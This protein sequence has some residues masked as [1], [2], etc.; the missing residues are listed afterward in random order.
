[1]AATKIRGN[2]QILD[3]TILNAQ[4][5]ASAAIA[6]SKLADGAEFL[7]RNGS[8]ALTGNL[9]ANS[10]RIVNL[11]APVDPNDAARKADVEIAALGLSV[12]SAVRVATVA[13]LPDNTRTGNVLTAD[14]D[15]AL[16]SID[17][18]SLSV[19]NRLL[20]KDEATGANNGI[21]TV[22]DLG[23]GSNPFV[24][25]RATDADESSEVV[26][27]IFMFVSEGT[28]LADTGWVLNTNAPITLNTTALS[29]TQ[30]SGVSGSGDVDGGANVGT[31]GT[32]LFK[33]K[34]GSTLQFHKLNNVDGKI[35]IALDGGSDEVRLSI[36]AGSLVNADISASAAIA[37]SK[38]AD[39][40]ANHVIINDGSGVLSSEA[41]LSLDRLATGSANSVL[42]GQGAGSSTYGLITNS[43]VDAAA[44]IART[45]LASGSAH[46]LVVNDASGVMI[47]AAAITAARALISDA[48]GI[49]THSSVTSTELGHLSG[50]TS[51]IQTQLNN[52]LA[53]S[54]HIIREAPTGAINGS[55]DIFELAATPI[56]GK[57]QVFLNGLLQRPGSGN[58]Y[59]IS[60][61]TITFEDAPLTGDVL[62]VSYIVA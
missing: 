59:T 48:N 22:T 62:L 35:N 38:L 25:T 54:N 14:D 10:N 52:K 11:A 34:S 23:D 39:G 30:F 42:I 21:Y 24:L 60:G 51:A 41:R 31:A 33:Q 1:M 9:N 2:T 6:T 26:P 4:I 40:S 27:N 46:R 49:P 5:S 18:V 61:D 32:G 15:G 58:D 8:V 43:N 20:V 12:K 37:R 28:T 29:F 36:A 16:P 56:A 3:G 45:K 47:D 13:A 50:V 7:Q 55:N 57:E 17:G 44:A 53:G 19:G